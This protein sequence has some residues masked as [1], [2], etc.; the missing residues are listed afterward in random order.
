M[1]QHKEAYCLML[2]ASQDGHKEQIWN[3]RDG[4]TPFVIFL[5]GREMRHVDWHNDEYR[6]SYVPSVGSHVFIDLT[7]E[8]ATVYSAAY[9]EHWWDHPEKPMSKHPYWGAIGK[10]KTTIVLAT[11]H[12]DTGDPPPD[13]VSVTPE[14]WAV[15]NR[16][17]QERR[18]KEN[19]RRQVLPQRRKRRVNY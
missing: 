13:L 1:K 7:L 10:K 12:M 9:V 4:V 19:K 16:R 5:N 2:Y 17:S 8:K 6:P 14:L 3:S 18:P 15:F 11:A